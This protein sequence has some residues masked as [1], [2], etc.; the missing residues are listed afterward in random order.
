MIAQANVLEFDHVVR[1]YDRKREVLRDVSFAMKPE[2]VVALV[3]RN[4][5]GK[6][7]LIHLAM[8]LLAP[9]KGTVR[10][11]G[12]NPT[13]HVVEVKR[14][15]GYVG[16]MPLLPPLF[17]VRDA[18]NFH[19]KLYPTWD[20]GFER[21]LLERF[22]L[23]AFTGQRLNKLSGGQKQQVSLL[24]AVSHR[25]ELLLLDEP[26]AGLDPAT[27][28]EF[29]E[30]SIQLLNRHGSAILFS[31]HHMGDVER[32]GGRL[33]LL[34]DGVIALDHSLDALREELCLAVVPRRVFANVDAL[35]AMP[36]VL[37]VR[38]VVDSLHAV[39][40]GDR[41]TTQQLW[42]ER[43]GSTEI[44]CS[45]LPLEELFIEMTGSQDRAE[46]AR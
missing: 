34:R 20:T 38:T 9:Q 24:C 27:R 36:E 3:G 35:R 39:V 41:W 19:R 6:S 30:T 8:G 5:T 17:T 28:R 40:R 15:I 32:L 23:A 14:R 13:D 11:F 21:D 10:V 45:P 46:V 18:I 2:E 37:H 43:L 26:A 22:G 33:L 42:R 25:P 7:T 44:D 4:G 16:Q 1:A 12:R 29:L 31:S